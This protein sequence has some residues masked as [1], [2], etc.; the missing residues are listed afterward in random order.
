MTGKG[1]G[2]NHTRAFLV[3]VN[4]PG[5]LM[6]GLQNKMGQHSSDLKHISFEGG[7]ILAESLRR[8]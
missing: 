4:A 8:H 3:P 5:C 6:A 7:R 1:A 2:K